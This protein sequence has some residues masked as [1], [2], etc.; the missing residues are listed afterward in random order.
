M[1]YRFKNGK[2]FIVKFYYLIIMYKCP[3]CNQPVITT[4][5]KINAGPWGLGIKKC[6]N[7][8]K[9]FAT[10]KW[11]IFIYAPLTFLII[12]DVFFPLKGITSSSSPPL[13]A[14]LLAEFLGLLIYV[15]LIIPIW[16]KIPLQKKE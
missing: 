10:P 15:I 2:G 1:S 5:Q 6:K 3:H 13:Q 8:G 7:C 14:A 16:L 4:W 12:I 9:K 11:S